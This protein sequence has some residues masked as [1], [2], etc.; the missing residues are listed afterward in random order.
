MSRKT[1][2]PVASSTVNPPLTV[3]LLLGKRRAYNNSSPPP[4]RR[5]S[6]RPPHR[7]PPRENSPAALGG[8]SELQWCGSAPGFLPGRP[9]DL[10]RSAAASLETSPVQGGPP[11]ALKARHQGSARAGYCSR[12]PAPNPRPAGSSGRPTTL[13]CTLRGVGLS[14]KETGP[15]GR[16]PTIAGPRSPTVVPRGTSARPRSPRP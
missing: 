10:L 2:A 9:V 6:P 7:P 4:A 3:L 1:L 5:G 14:A 8:P 12:G 13:P 11:R 16:R 15:L